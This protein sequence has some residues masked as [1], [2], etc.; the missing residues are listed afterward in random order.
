MIYELILLTAFGHLTGKH[1]YHPADEDTFKCP[2]DYQ[3]KKVMIHYEYT[4][5]SKYLHGKQR[6]IFNLTKI[7]QNGH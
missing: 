3:G 2:A 1:Y 6:R 4:G 5:E 7:E